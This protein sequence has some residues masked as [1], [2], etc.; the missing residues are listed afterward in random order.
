MSISDLKREL[1][2]AL[3]H[4]RRTW[5]GAERTL[6]EDRICSL[7]LQHSAV[8]H[9]RWIGSYLAFDGEVNL[10]SLWG[11]Q[12]P[13]LQAV[14]PQETTELT[15]RSKLVFPRHQSKQPLSFVRPHR[16]I[17]RGALPLPEGPEVPLEEIDVLL[18]PGVAFS[19]TQ[20]GRLGLG[21]GHYDRT[22]KLR[23]NKSWSVKAF[24]VGFSFQLRPQLPLEPWDAQLDGIFTEL[25]LLE[26]HYSTH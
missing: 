15:L 7:I 26:P 20:G 9:A 8:K 23:L 22:L 16:W 11:E 24:G 21:G 2:Q 6:A 4:Q 18:I 10:T 17:G 14:D 25:G 3:R 13:V 12:R 5:G 1:R 19:P